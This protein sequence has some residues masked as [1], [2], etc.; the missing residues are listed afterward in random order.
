MSLASG[1]TRARRAVLLV[2]DPSWDRAGAAAA[3]LDAGLLPMTEPGAGRA[4]ALAADPSVG[5]DAVVLP[6]ALR[7][8]SAAELVGRLRAHRPQI[9][10][11]VLGPGTE[12]PPSPSATAGPVVSLEDAADPEKLA[13]ALR[14]WLGVP[15]PAS[16]RRLRPG[17]VP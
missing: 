8:M 9:P 4:V 5:F 7:E 13:E 1:A 3:L 2:D 17:A 10:I 16:G 15:P 14:T 12:L 6:A 11:L